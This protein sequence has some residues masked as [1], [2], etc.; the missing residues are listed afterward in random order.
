VTV[1][2]E[3]PFSDLHRLTL[4]LAPV[5]CQWRCGC[6]VS[7]HGFS[8]DACLEGWYDHKLAAWDALEA[9]VELEYERL[10]EAGLA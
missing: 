4:D 9:E 8:I 7:G 10:R 3:I 1:V 6:G 2:D 5:L